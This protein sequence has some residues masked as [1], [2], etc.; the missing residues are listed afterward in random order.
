MFS[1]IYEPVHGIIYKNSKKEKRVMRHLE[2]HKFCDATLNR[3]LEGLK[4]YNNNVKFG[5]EQRKLTDDEV[6]YLKL[7]EEEIEVRLKYRNQ[8]RRWEI[9]PMDTSEKLMPNNGQA[10]SQL[11]CS[12]VIG[13]LMYAMACTRP[14]IAFAVVKLSMYTS[15][16]GA[17]G[18]E[19]KWLRNLMLEI[20]LWSKPIALISIRCASATMLARA[21]SQMYNGKSRHLNVRHSMIPELIMNGG[22]IV[23]YYEIGAIYHNKVI[24]DYLYHKKLHEPLAVAKPA[25]MKAKDW[26]LLMV[27]LRATVRESANT[28]RSLSKMEPLISKELKLLK[29]SKGQTAVLYSRWCIIAAHMHDLGASTDILLLAD[30]IMLRSTQSES[31]T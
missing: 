23:R 6:E 19:A 22:G 13:C 15:N 4:S 29:E 27:P 31:D 8:M 21:Y 5:Y 10:V 20:P 12:R 9:T 28:Q 17:A 11:V 25:G 30:E 24:E 7:F 26:T 1:I 18:K 16:P 3:V 14:D 2:I